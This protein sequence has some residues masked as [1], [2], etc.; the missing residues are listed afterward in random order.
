MVIFVEWKKVKK[1]LDLKIYVGK[2]DKERVLRDNII[3][4]M[5]LFENHDVFVQ[6]NCWVKHYI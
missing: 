2:S 5:Y 3:S 1:T 6:R 4:K